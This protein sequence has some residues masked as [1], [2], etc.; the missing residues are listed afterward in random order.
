MSKANAIYRSLF[1]QRYE[2]YKSCNLSDD[3]RANMCLPPSIGG[4]WHGF[5]RLLTY[6]ASGKTET[7]ALL[8]LQELYQWIDSRTACCYSRPLPVMDER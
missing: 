1:S 8:T 6:L 4:Q 7:G 2:F 3:Y 5:M